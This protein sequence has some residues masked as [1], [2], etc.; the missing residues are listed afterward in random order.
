MTKFGHKRD[1]DSKS[2]A[3]SNTQAIKIDSVET[4]PIEKRAQ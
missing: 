1:C 2:L 4:A 3:L